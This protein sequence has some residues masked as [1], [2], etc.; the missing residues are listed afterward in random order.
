MPTGRFSGMS[1]VLSAAQRNSEGHGWP[2]NLA[3]FFDFVEE[4]LR[5]FRCGDGCCGGVSAESSSS[6]TTGTGGARTGKPSHDTVCTSFALA[7]GGDGGGV[8]I[9]GANNDLAS[10]KKVSWASSKRDLRSGVGRAT[11]REGRGSPHMPTSS[12]PM[13]ASP[14]DGTSK[15]KS[16]KMACGGNMGAGFTRSREAGKGTHLRRRRL[17]AARARPGPPGSCP[18]TP[19]AGA[20]RALRRTRTTALGRKTGRAARRA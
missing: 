16:S 4:L 7:S 6:S 1:S 17:H 8:T 12:F 10:P 14:Q 13:R 3:A 2:R 19:R 18:R 20:R 11:K 5:R 9:F 15:T